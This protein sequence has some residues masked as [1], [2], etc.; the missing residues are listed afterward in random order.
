[1]TFGG[2]IQDPSRLVKRATEFL[3][4]FKQPQVQLAIPTISTR[5]SR[6]T[7]QPGLSFKLNFD[8]A[9]FQDDE[10]SGF[11]VVIR[12]NSGEVMAVLSKIILM[13]PFFK[14]MRRRGGDP[15]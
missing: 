13:L 7:P 11:G 8:V 5:S 6:W 14:T 9:I 1:M 10:A 15:K 12:N 3:N 4:E 2:V